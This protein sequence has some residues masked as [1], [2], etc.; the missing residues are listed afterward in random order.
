MMG[1]FG[2]MSRRTNHAMKT[3]YNDTDRDFKIGSGRNGAGKPVTAKQKA[4]YKRL[5][6]LAPKPRRKR[7][8]QGPF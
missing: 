5:K 7:L 8:L 6:R 2:S 3:S 4:F 1:L